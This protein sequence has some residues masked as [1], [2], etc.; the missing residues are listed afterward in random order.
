M[1]T[2]LARFIHE[3]DGQDLIEYGLLLGIITVACM[4]AIVSIGGK[5]V[6]YYEALDTSLK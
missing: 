5:I 1:R 6:G 4:T 2:L 3:E